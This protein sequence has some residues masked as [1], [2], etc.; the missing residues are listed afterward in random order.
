MH[1]VIPM[2]GSGERFAKAGYSLPKPLIEVDGEPIIKYVV[3]MFSPADRF[4]FI[5]NEKHLAATNL[6]SIL[7]SISPS[8]R[9]VAIKPHKTG[10][11]GAVSQCLDLM[12][13]AEETIVNYCDFYSL[14]NYADFLQTTR[15]RKAAGAIVAYRN[16]HPH[17][18]G[19]DNYAFIK[20]KNLWLEAIQEKKPFTSN[21]M[22]EFASNGTY[23][24]ARGAYVKKY[25]TDLIRREVTV[26]GEFYVSMIYNLM[27]EDGL[28][29]SIYE[30]SN[31]LQWGT[32]AD[33]EEYQRWSNYF[34]D[35][36]RSD[37]TISPP[38]VDICLVPMA[39]RGI[40]F[41]EAG[42]KLP[43]PLIPVSARPMVIQA[44]ES[45]PPAN[46]Y[47]FVALKEHLCESNLASTLQAN[48]K[49]T[50]I[51][52]LDEV[53]EGQAI[54]CQVGIERAQPPVDR[55]QSILIGACDNAV[56]YN[57][58]A[59]TQLLSDQ[60]WDVCAFSF[61]NH[62]SSSRR[63]EMYGWL[64]VQD[65]LEHFPKLTG[66]SVKKPISDNPKNDHAVV[67]AFLFRKVS[68]FE[69][70]LEL[71][72]MKNERVNGEFYADSLIATAIDLG[73]RCVAFEVDQY[74]CFGTPDD[75]RTFEY[76]QSFFHR[77]PWHP[78]NIGLDQTV[79]SDKDNLVS[80]LAGANNAK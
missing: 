10:P 14:W 7:K 54:S 51:V 27:V 33:L 24:F 66:V 19:T 46:R 37:R 11:V 1:V 77:C 18:L 20:E 36:V 35:L 63:P 25:F 23:F 67:G 8:G 2:S 70:S 17:M 58:G 12:D 68:T 65:K 71:L 57:K 60:N 53:T 6:E 41:S 56:V 43:K 64:K 76:W 4:T 48:F 22:Q 49:D 40:R 21:R 38:P 69:K 50:S 9:V 28:P 75:L 72:K 55:E 13:D 31:M 52:S 73:F 16:F 59:Y 62:P 39:G 34:K 44:T 30:V 45:L 80:K 5:C 74:I 32:P 26:N 47:I 3:S 29:V 78:Y 61:R 79:G 42:Y 15:D